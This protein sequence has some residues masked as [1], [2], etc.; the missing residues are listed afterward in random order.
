MP[1]NLW[2]EII[3]VLPNFNGAAIGIWE[4]ISNFIPHFIMDAITSPCRHYCQ[5]VLLCLYRPER[6]EAT[7][8]EIPKYGS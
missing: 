5:I 3:H 4:W 6:K 8:I 1:S 7:L 2:D